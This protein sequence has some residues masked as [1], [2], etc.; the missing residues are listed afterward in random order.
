MSASGPPDPSPGRSGLRTTFARA[1]RS[2]LMLVIAAGVVV[3]IAA[4]AVGR[5]V[6]SSPAP[7]ASGPAAAPST[8]AASPAKAQ[9]EPDPSGYVRFRSRNA[10]VPFSIAYPRSWSRVPSD[11]PQVELIVAEGRAASMLVRVTPVGLTVTRETLPIVRDLTDRLVR[12]D[13]RVRLTNQPRP[14]VLAGLPGYRYDYTF[15]TATGEPG[16]HVHYF[17]FKEGQMITMVF[18]TLP[19]RR[20]EKY[21]PVFDRI[22]STFESGG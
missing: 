7:Q 17:L 21:L 15:D 16:A 13:G 19:A 4:A 1:T 12:A 22:V 9:A 2:P 14:L 8:T 11:D 3:L 5:A 6:V 10:E 20:L 18:Q